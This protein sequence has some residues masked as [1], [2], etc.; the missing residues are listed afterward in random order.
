MA[1]AK[2]VAEELDRAALEAKREE[3]L[4]GLSF[5]KAR[6]RQISEAA[7]TGEI[8]DEKLAE[9]LAEAERSVSGF[10]R[11]LEGLGFAFERVTAQEK[12]REEAKRAAERRDTAVEILALVHQR[13]WATEKLDEAVAAVGPAFEHVESLGHR[14]E[15][16]AS[17]FFDDDLRGRERL[18]NFLMNIDLFGM[19]DT[20]Y[21]FNQAQL[22]SPGIFAR[23]LP[24]ARPQALRAL[25]TAIPE[26]DDSAVQEEA[27]ERARPQADDATEN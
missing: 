4:D 12:E 19:T 23:H 15:T 17:G 26:V 27:L 18:R 9:K 16:M 5:A 2:K 10:E 8:S 13:F 7:A 25:A 11:R 1:Q 24:L 20:V 21:R 22:A 14:I 3:L 6:L